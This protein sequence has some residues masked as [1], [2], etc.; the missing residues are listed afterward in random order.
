MKLFFLNLIGKG[1]GYLYNITSSLPLAVIMTAIIMFIVKKIVGL[2]LPPLNISKL[3][4]ILEKYIKNEQNTEYKSIGNIKKTIKKN[5]LNDIIKTIFSFILR[6][7]VFLLSIYVFIVIVYSPEYVPGINS[8]EKYP[9][10]FIP[11]ILE[12]TKNILLPSICVLFMFF[13]QNMFRLKE[14]IIKNFSKNIFRIAI[15]IVLFTFYTMIF[16]QIYLLYIMT[17]IILN[18]VFSIIK[19]ILGKNKMS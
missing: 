13:S 18:T 8:F 6:I 14:A 11:N 15:L 17:T 7:M 12:K 19:M 5:K 4:V 3:N 9:F 1:I 16:G 2:V 10:L